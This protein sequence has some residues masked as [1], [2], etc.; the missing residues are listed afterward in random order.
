[1]N[2]ESKFVLHII[3][4]A[5][6]IFGFFI[7][8]AVLVCLRYNDYEQLKVISVIMILCILFGAIGQKSFR[9]EVIRVTSRICFMTTIFTW[10]VLIV[11]TSF[12]F[13]FCSL[14][15]SFIDAVFEAVAAWT[16]T[17][18]SVIDSDVMPI[19]LQML[20]ASCNW[21]GGLGIIVLALTFLPTWQFVGRSLVVTELPGPG[22]IKSNTTFRKAY[23]RSLLVYIG[24]TVFQYILLRLAGMP[25]SQALITALSNISTSGLVHIN[26]GNIIALSLS[27]KIIITLFAFFGSLNFSVFIL[28]SLRKIHEAFRNPELKFHSARIGITTIIISVVISISTGYTSSGLKEIGNILMQ[29]TSYFSTS[30]F[31]V[32]NTSTWPATCKALIIMQ[33]FI[34][35]SAISSGGGI[36]AARVIIAFKTSTSTIYRYIHRNIIKPIHY[37]GE[38]LKLNTLL[39]SNLFIAVF[40][41]S[42]LIG[43]TILS[44]DLDIRSALNTSVAMLSNT[45]SYIG[46]IATPNTIN[47]YSFLSKLTMCLLMLAGRLEIYPILLIFFRGFW[48]SN[49]DFI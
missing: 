11:I 49:K 8:P 45:G 32:T 13:Y 39:R 34:G 9:G 33:L 41:I 17:G 16:T 4:T 25:R 35:A 24:L 29:V 37:D 43:A 42:Y 1:M 28:L 14:N 5:V 40:V 3:S 22:F 36:K 10:L 23:R 27:V 15:M 31:I 7:I 12:P 19:G 44:L 46:Q 20:R 30:G 21:M 26:N 47:N 38:A 6:M 2:K 18:I 48:R